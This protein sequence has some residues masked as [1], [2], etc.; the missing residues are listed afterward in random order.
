MPASKR[1]KAESENHLTVFLVFV[2]VLLVHPGFLSEWI[3]GEK[4]GKRGERGER[5]ERSKKGQKGKRGK[6]RGEGKEGE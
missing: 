5:G 2:E 4:R 1:P 3:M 6:H